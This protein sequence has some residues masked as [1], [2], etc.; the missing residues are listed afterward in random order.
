MWQLSDVSLPF[1]ALLRRPHICKCERTELDGHETAAAICKWRNI[2][3][4]SW[5]RALEWPWDR[6]CEPALNW[7]LSSFMADL[8]MAAFCSLLINT[9]GFPQGYSKMS[10]SWSTPRNTLAGDIWRWI[11]AHLLLLASV[12]SPDRLQC[13]GVFTRNGK[14]FTVNHVPVPVLSFDF[15]PHIALASLHCQSVSIGTRTN[16]SSGRGGGERGSWW[17]GKGRADEVT[18]S[19]CSSIKW[20]VW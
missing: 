17:R 19:L 16:N 14:Q 12:T 10:P 13:V 20:K 2:L 9:A 11:F 18:Y 4:L 3:V 8:S 6:E 15:T 1:V 5:S 7:T